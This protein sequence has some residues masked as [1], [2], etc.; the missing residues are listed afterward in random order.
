MESRAWL[1]MFRVIPT[2]GI[3]EVKCDLDGDC[4]SH[5]DLYCISVSSLCSHCVQSQT[6]RFFTS[7]D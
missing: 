5:P 3:L 2:L 6:W 7:T 4:R 1:K